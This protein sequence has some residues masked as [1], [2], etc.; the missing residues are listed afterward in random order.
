MIGENPWYLPWPVTGTTIKTVP[1]RWPLWPCAT[2]K[3]Q[4]TPLFRRTRPS[5]GN[6]QG[7]SV[8][9]NSLPYHTTRTYN[10]TIAKLPFFLPFC[11]R[12]VYK[13][14]APFLLEEEQFQSDSHNLCP[15]PDLHPSLLPDST[16]S[17]LGLTDHPL[18]S[19]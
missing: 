6:R 5:I 17:S 13:I 19:L 18:L 11:W 10:Q 12:P 9:A 8:V 7:R 14:N 3:G 16:V 15:L 2:S 4:C 1:R